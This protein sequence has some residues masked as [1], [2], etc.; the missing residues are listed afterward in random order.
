LTEKQVIRRQL[1]HQLEALWSSETLLS[2]IIKVYGEQLLEAKWTDRR[3]AVEMPP[4]FNNSVRYH[5]HYCVRM[6]GYRFIPL[7]TRMLGLRC[8]LNV[9]LLRREEPG[10]ILTSGGDLDNR[11]KILFDGLRMPHVAQELTGLTPPFKP[12]ETCFCLLDD[13]SIVTKLSI[14][15]DR[16][17][18][19][20]RAGENKNDVELTIRV[21]PQVV[22]PCVANIG[23]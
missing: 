3:G 7:V 11:V 16:L 2:E 14:E 23:W 5:Y 22:D 4:E 15:T 17:L 1:H 9:L 18:R 13:D 19:P 12:D 8:H 10:R 21:R 20:L 6:G